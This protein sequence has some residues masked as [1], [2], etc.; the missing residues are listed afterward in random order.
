M[1]AQTVDRL[2]GL[3][4][5]ENI[6][7]ITNTEQVAGVREV[8]PQLAPEQ[9][10]AEPVGRDTAAAVGL[11]ALLVARRDPEAVFAMLPAD[12]VIHDGAG[13][14]KTLQDAFAVALKEPALVTVGIKPTSPATGYGYI[15]AGEALDGEKNPVYRVKRFVEKPS[16]EKAESYIAS[17]DYY[18]NAG[19]FVW[20]V[21]AIRGAFA[22]HAPEL[23]RGLQ[24]MESDLAAGQ[25][26]ET[27]LAKHYPSLEKI[28]ID[29]AI[30][31]KAENRL[32]VPS[33]FDWDDVGEWPAVARH[34]QPDA[35]GNV[36][37]GHALVHQAGGN[38]ILSEGQH[39][40]AALGVDDLIVVHTAEAT[41]ICPKNRAQDIKKLLAELYARPELKFTV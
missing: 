25:R 12:H 15:Q 30:M 8:C 19:M 10:V 26:L 4:P 3:V 27:V 2:A 23:N 38:I 1:L 41:L 17:G 6:L 9:V 36:T 34:H 5:P 29:F 14:R 40:V 33:S 7:I 35:Q 39:L 18:W 32:T 24:A 28:S 16:L 21:D 20:T 37:R 13:F 31:E 22:K 11:A